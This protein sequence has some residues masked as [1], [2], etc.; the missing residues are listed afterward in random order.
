MRIYIHESENKT[1]FNKRPKQLALTLTI[2]QVFCNQKTVQ[3]ISVSIKFEQF[4]KR[5]QRIQLGMSREQIFASGEPVTRRGRWQIIRVYTCY[6]RSFTP[7]NLFSTY[8]KLLCTKIVCTSIDE[9]DP[10]TT[11]KATSKNRTK[12]NFMKTA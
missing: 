9:E 12:Q 5:T 6:T 3:K 10:L 8:S 7:F 2:S 4:L 11:S 1:L